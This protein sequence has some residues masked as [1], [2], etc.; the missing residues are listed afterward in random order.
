M[1]ELAVKAVND[2]ENMGCSEAESYIQ[3]SKETVISTGLTRDRR[4]KK[5]ICIGLRT[6]IKDKKGFAA[7]TL[8]MC[9]LEEIE[10]ASFHVCERA[11][12]DPFWKHLPYKK[13]GKSPEGIYD[14]ILG[15]MTEEDLLDAVETVVDTARNKKCAATCTVLSRVETIA[16]A[17][18]HGVQKSYQAT[19]VDITIHCSHK[20][21]EVTSE[22]HSRNFNV[23]LHK[24][25]EKTVEKVLQPK[26]FSKID[27]KFCG[28]AIFLPEAV[29][30]LFFPCLRWAVN[31]ENV[32]SE[33]S[34]VADK[35]GEK[36]ASP[37]LTVTDDGLLSYGI[38][39]APFD[40]EGNPMEKTRIVEKGV[41]SHVIYSE[42]TANKYTAASTGN[43]LRSATR[44]PAID[45]TNFIIKPGSCS[46]DALI[47]C[48]DEGVII[49]DFRGDIDPSGGYFNGRCEG[50]YIKKG[51]TQY[52]VRNFHIQG[53]VFESLQHVDG[54]G[55]DI[56]CSFE[57]L[58]TAPLLISDITIF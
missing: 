43:A 32:H 12:P 41:F 10:K 2:L 40:G 23:D 16:V 11:A 30:F 49:T 3:D 56:E 17:N 38:R 44:E 33:K 26:E 37:H 7:G 15:T 20:N 55:K 25:V 5:D 1:E 42:Y 29:Q 21:N 53:N 18:T 4:V 51:T 22:W 24:L 6:F 8:P 58:Y 50:S 31:A 19:K 54:V 34:W 9:S 14:T 36:I 47:A 48:V 13:E 45:T 35:M 39:S 28:S 46:L 27:H 57:G 52:D